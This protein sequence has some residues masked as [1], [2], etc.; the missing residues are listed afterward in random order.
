MS[1]QIIFH[2]NV[3]TLYGKPESMASIGAELWSGLKD[4]P[5]DSVEGHASKDRQ[6]TMYY[7]SQKLK[8]K[9]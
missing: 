3:C 8:N 2:S 4:S 9:E 5:V 7:Y 1:S 6:K